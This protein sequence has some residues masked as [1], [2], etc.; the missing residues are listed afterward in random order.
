M[1]NHSLILVALS[2]LLATTSGSIVTSSSR[3]VDSNSE[4]VFHV[5]DAPTPSEGILMLPAPE[6]VV[7]VAFEDPNSEDVLRIV[8]MLTAPGLYDNFSIPLEFFVVFED[9]EDSEGF[10][11]SEDVPDNS[12][13]FPNVLEVPEVL[14][15]DSEDVHDVKSLKIAGFIA[16]CILFLVAYSI[17]TLDIEMET[18]EIRRPMRVYRLH[19]AREIRTIPLIS[20]QNVELIRL[21][22]ESDC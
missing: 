18:M 2:L 1:T 20:R 5:S 19:R 4:R 9:S 8:Y 13:T 21:E 12:T 11:D 6:D 15:K 17:C 16:Q 10:E 22:A 3:H 7:D 14:L